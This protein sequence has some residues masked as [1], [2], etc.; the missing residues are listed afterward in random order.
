MSVFE[1]ICT[2]S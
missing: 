1:I 2:L